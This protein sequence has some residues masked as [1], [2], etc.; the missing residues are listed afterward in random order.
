MPTYDYRC[1]ANGQVIEV[2]HSMRDKMTTWSE[3]CQ[4]AGIEVGNTPAD[5]PVERLANGGQVVKSSTLGQPDLPP[6]ATGG[7]CS[8]GGCGFN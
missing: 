1:A 6:C 3:L 5:A 4:L 2:K 7:G 8:S